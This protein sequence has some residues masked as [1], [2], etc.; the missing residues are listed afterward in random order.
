MIARWRLLV[1]CLLWATTLIVQPTVEAKDSKPTIIENKF[2]SEPIGLFY[3]EDTDTVLF[4]DVITGNL[5]RSF[6]GGEKFEVVAGKDGEMKSQILAMRPHFFDKNKA[7]FLGKDGRHWITTDQGKSFRSFEIEAFPTWSTDPLKF[8]GWDSRKVMFTGKSCFAFHCVQ[9]TFYTTDDF[10]TVK[11]LRDGVESCAWAVGEPRFG[12]G[13][14]VDTQIEDRILCVLAGLKGSGNRLVYTDDYFKD[15]ADGTEVK[16]QHGRP[17]SGVLNTAAVTKYIVAAARS[18]GTDEH[19]LFVSDD[20]ITWHR[21]EFGKHRLEEDAYTIL[22]STNYSIQVDV[23]TSRHFDGMGVLFTSNSNGT[24]FTKNIE[25]TNREDG[26]VDFEKIANIQ[27]IVLVNTVKN[28]EE[29]E[30]QSEE[31]KVVSHISF[32]DGRTF[33]DLKVGD[34]KLHLHSVT[35]ISNSGLVFSSPAPGIVMG[36]GNTGE[37]LKKYSEGN[38]YVSDDAGVTWRLALKGSHKYEF[39]D[40]GSVIMAISDNEK[41]DEISY[42]INHGK[43]WETAKLESKVYPIILT[44]TPDS[45]SLKFVLVGATSRRPDEEHVIV[46]ID[47]SGLHERKCK[48]DDFE[49]WTARLD[50]SGEPD[51]LMG[52]KQ[53]YHRRKANA[54]CFVNEEFK[55]P[56]PIFEPCKCSAEDFECDYNF[57][58]S[59]DRKSCEP[60]V[61]LTPPKGVCQKAGDKYKGPS[62]WRLIPGNT[63]IREGGKNL[64]AEIE[65]SCDDA[66][67]SPADGAISTKKNFFDG[68][69]RRQFNYLER[70]STSSGNDETVMMLTDKRNL[71]ISHN[72]GKKWDQ[73]QQMK[74]QK[75]AQIAPHQH[76]SDGA[77]FLTDNTK[78]FYTND[79]GHT[80]KSFK[81][82]GGRDSNGAP[83]LTFHPQFK[84][85]LIWVGPEKCTIKDCPSNAYFSKNNGAAWELILKHVTSCMFVGKRA[86]EESGDR[87]ICSQRE[88]ENPS[89]PLHL[90]SSDNFFAE[91]KVHFRDISDFAAMSEYIVVASKDPE[92]TTSMKASTSLDGETFADAHFPVNVD[93][94]VQSAYTVVDSSNHAIFL[95]VTVNKYESTAYGSL[96]KSNSNGTS[97]VLSRAGVNRNGYGYIDFEKMD[98]PEGVVVINVVGNLEAMEKKGAMKKLKTMITHNDGGEWTFLPPPSKDADGNSFS[99]SAKNGEGS[100]QCALHLHGYTERKDPWDTF[101]S[102]S[103]IGLMMGVGNVGGQLESWSDAD[104]FLTQDGGITWKAVKKGRYIY[105]YGDSGSVIAIVPDGQ[106]TKSL[107]YSLDE[108]ETWIEYQFTETETHVDD[109]TT[110]PSDTSK[111]FLLWGKEKEKNKLVTIN[112]DFS[113]LRSH[114]CRLNEDNGEDE[115][116]DYYLW[117]PKHPLQDDNCLFGHVEQYH[118]KKPSADCWNNW[119]EPHVHSIGKN[120]TCTRADYEW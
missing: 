74:N 48:K 66:G 98:G 15:D 34:D 55:D 60:A 14:G 79:R 41:T 59:E 50:E 113:G 35:D 71:Y 111:M 36:V 49:K 81:A 63:C 28:W 97:F 10:K 26:M 56:V 94:P 11:L 53:S 24:Y 2:E 16:L 72:H 70:Q 54:D 112:V 80:I 84:D 20:S 100:D 108:G 92:R 118:R 17:V 107:F 22:A 89:N 42:S 30:K 90:V 38:L 93:I 51:C 85:W 117:E 46:A 32:D 57:V 1:S 69:D 73:P 4:Q 95:H 3:F 25:H 116:D 12:V 13:L 58:R 23:L 18:P 68:E 114:S 40:Q 6:D 86:G 62:G 8:H 7:Y 39:G 110:V 76:Y 78:V 120:C 104:T 43:D 75:I 102:G 52:H 103:A 101:S 106:A 29:V 5:H 82:P 44:T 9:S 119:R 31:K 96:I 65:R 109:I 27:G 21:A 105:E 37:A 115:D 33:Q 45:T 64:D 61:A 77:F 47:F 88:N 99:C 83:P 91:K 87:I 67:S 19:A